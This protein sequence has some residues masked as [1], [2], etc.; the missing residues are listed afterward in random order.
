MTLDFLRLIIFSLIIFIISC[1]SA[2]KKLN[3]AP[4]GLNKRQVLSKFGN[5]VEK[6]RKEGKDYWVFESLKK[7]KNKE[8]LVYKHVFIFESGTLIEKSYTR[9]FTTEEMQKFK[10]DSNDHS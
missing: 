8:W 9:S 5:P 1:T 3:T 4:V 10:E 2:H 6:Y 7:A